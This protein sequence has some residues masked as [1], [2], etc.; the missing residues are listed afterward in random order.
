MTILGGANCEGEMAQGILSLD[1]GVDFVFSGES[2]TAFPKFLRDV[3]SGRLPATR[4]VQGQPCV[5]FSTAF[6]TPSFAEYYEQFERSPP[7][8]TRTS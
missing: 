5:D 6:L 3:Q 8:P 7:S 4:V 2:E 1:G